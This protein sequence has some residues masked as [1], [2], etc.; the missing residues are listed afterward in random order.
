MKYVH[1]WSKHYT[2]G[3]LRPCLLRITVHTLVWQ[4]N[5]G[6]PL[7]QRSYREVLLAK[8]N[9]RT[10]FPSCRKGLGIYRSDSTWNSSL[11]GS[12]EAFLTLWCQEEAKRREFEGR[13]GFHTRYVFGSIMSTCVLQVVG[14]F[15]FRGKLTCSATLAFKL[16]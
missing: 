2:F 12:T 14:D 6:A 11:V 9:T 7:A 1:V 8:S 5:W 3:V 13:E 10:V 16:A 15:R 4:L